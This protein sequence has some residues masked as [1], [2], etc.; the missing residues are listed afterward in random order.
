MNTVDE[1]AAV[2]IAKKAP[3]TVRK[4]SDHITGLFKSSKRE[5]ISGH[6][7]SN[8][9][10]AEVRRHREDIDAEEKEIREKEAERFEEN[11]KEDREAVERFREEEERSE[12]EIF[13]ENAE[14]DR[15]EVE[16]FERNEEENEKE[17]IVS[18][19]DVDGKTALHFA[20]ADGDLKAVQTILTSHI[21]GSIGG[22]NNDNYDII[23][24]RDINGWQ[25][26]HEA[27]RGGYLDVLR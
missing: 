14:K 12:A 15:E 18:P 10:E 11:E 5:K 16:R 9:D 2:E 1:A 24:A 25:A 7:G 3:S 13:E 8:H 22:G 19:D 21:S 17:D 20:A 6:E 26:H 23:H 27:V 4:I